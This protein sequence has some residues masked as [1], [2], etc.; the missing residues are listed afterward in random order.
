M[1]FKSPNLTRDEN[2]NDQEDKA[3]KDPEIVRIMKEQEYLRQGQRRMIFED[4]SLQT[5]QRKMA[6]E[7]YFPSSNTRIV[8][9]DPKNGSSFDKKDEQRET[10]YKKPKIHANYG[11]DYTSQNS[12]ESDSEIQRTYL[13]HQD[14]EEE[15]KG[16][17]FNQGVDMLDS[18]MQPHFQNVSNTLQ[19]SP[20]EINKMDMTQLLKQSRQNDN[21]SQYVEAKGSL[22]QQLKKY[23]KYSKNSSEKDYLLTGHG[24]VFINAEKSMYKRKNSASRA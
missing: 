15:K 21:Q 14:Y 11:R 23:S 19:E 3:D 2:Q 17:H 4:Q 24:K 9:V 8:L 7:S 1:L 6:L 5:K 10:I 16:N 22:Q 20:L 18:Y 13:K 12:D